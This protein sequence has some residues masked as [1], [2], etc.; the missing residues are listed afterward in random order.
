MS[1]AKARSA[2][3]CCEQPPLKDRPLMTPI[4]AGGLAA[5]FKVLANDTRLRLLHALVRADEMCVTDLAASRR[6]EGPGR[7]EP[8]PAA[9]RP[10]H[11]GVPPGR[12]Q[13]PL[14]AGGR[15]RGRAARTGVVPDGRGRRP[16]RRHGRAAACC[17]GE[18]CGSSPPRRSARSVLVF[19]GTGAVVVNDTH[20]RGRHARRRRPD[21]RAGR[22]GDDLRGRATCPAAT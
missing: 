4:Q 17:G 8:T 14:P 18:E 13:H 19:A 15:V 6:D 22:P 11:P 10:R 9:L 21:L 12:Q 7:L 2:T 1:K 20:R 5:V 16:D 3:E